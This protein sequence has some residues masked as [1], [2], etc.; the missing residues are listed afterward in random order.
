MNGVRRA[1]HVLLDHREVREAVKYHLNSDTFVFDVETTMGSPRRN[2]LRWV[3]IGSRGRIDVIPCGHPKGIVLVPEHKEKV[4][5]FT[6][7]GPEDPRSYTKLGK[8][9]YRAIDVTI[10]TKYGVAPAQLYPHEVCELLEPLMF[11]DR[12]KAGHNV[13]FDL[14]TVAKYYDDEIPPPPYHDTIILRHVQ[15]E[16]LIS[17]ELKPLIGDWFRVPHSERPKW[18]PNLGKEGVDNFGLDQ[19][20]RY[21]AKDVRY[22]WLF[23]QF[24][25]DRLHRYGLDSVYE[26]EMSCYPSIMKMEQVGFPVDLTQLEEV[27]Q[28]LYGRIAACEQKVYKLVGDTFPLNNYDAKRW[29]LFGEGKGRDPDT[30]FKGHPVRGDNDR[31]LKSFDLPVFFRTK[32]TEVAQVTAAVL[33]LYDNRGVEIAGLLAEFSAL[34]KLRGTFIDGMRDFLVPSK[35]GGLPRVHTGYKQH[36]TRTGRLSSAQPNIQQLPRGDA[37]RKLFVADDGYI[38]IVCDYDQIELRA[39]GYLS[40]DENM[41]GVF[42]RGE[43]IHRQAAASMYRIALEDVTSEQRGVGKVQNFAVLYGAGEDKIAAV[44]RCSKARAH[45]MIA[46]YYT[47]FPKLEPWKEREL[48]AARQRGD[49]SEPLTKP[50]YV[51][52]P[53]Y[54]RQR[55]LPN[56]FQVEMRSL[57]N[58]AERQAINALCQGFAGSITKMAMREL[59]VVLPSHSNMIAQVHDEIVTL[60]P[61][62]YAEEVLEQVSSV[63]SNVRNPDTGA[64]I[65]GDIPLVVSGAMG[66]SW[67]DAKDK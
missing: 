16:D 56:L 10:P 1:P 9:S 19:I 53:P 63:M 40:G 41:T 55:R 59:H 65:L 3:G 25:L 18:Y 14:Q 50:P 44:A 61:I 34:E 67:A 60:A 64:P 46:D 5:A 15:H 31:V 38:L 58:Q 4:P 21:L 29:V 13:K 37:I 49:R 11:S 47:G 17:Y 12:Y 20:A 33:E 43:D 23:L 39:A 2:E 51:V 45:R 32:K 30:G 36:G 7:F 35:N 6:H 22:C 24:F 26:F 54:G 57:K 27:A 8:P 48:R 52:I 28:D 66:H 42:A 62:K